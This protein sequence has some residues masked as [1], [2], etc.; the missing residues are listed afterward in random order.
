M[1]PA[2]TLLL[3]IPLL[4]A[5]QP[6]HAFFCFN[7]FFGGKAD[8]SHRHL[9]RHGRHLLY[10]YSPIPFDTGYAY[11]YPI[12]YAFPPPA[13]IPEMPAAVVVPAKPTALQSAQ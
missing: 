12:H 2:M 3:L 9:N 1:K 5:H 4:L 6:A 10:P 13:P 11:P 7:F 8:A